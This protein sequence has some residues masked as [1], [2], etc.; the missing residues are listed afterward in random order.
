MIILQQNEIRRQ[1][2]QR[3]LEYSLVPSLLYGSLLM[4]WYSHR[5]C[6]LKRDRLK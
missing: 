3:E 5:K 6:R 4:V 1:Q 2:E